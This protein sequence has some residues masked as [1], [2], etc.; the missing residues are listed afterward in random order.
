MGAKEE[1]SNAHK[2]L[3]AQLLS[4]FRTMTIETSNSIIEGSPIDTGRFR[5][6]WQ[7][8]TGTPVEG[9]LFDFIKKDEKVNAVE[10]VEAR[11]GAMDLNTT[12][13]L[14]NNLPYAEALEYGWS[15]QRP[16][17]WVRADVAAAQAIVNEALKKIGG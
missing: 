11:V 13:Y 9:T 14:T 7:A 5:G 16:S 15:A 1:L 12:V 10:N 4:L 3:Q 6:N 17:G 2:E 8:S